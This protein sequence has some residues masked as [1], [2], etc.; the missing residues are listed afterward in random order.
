M[1]H[2]DVY[3]PPDPSSYG[4]ARGENFVPAEPRVM[5]LVL[6]LDQE[7][8]LWIVVLIGYF[9]CQNRY[10]RVSNCH[11]YIHNFGTREKLIH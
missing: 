6:H 7:G 5:L 11:I 1:K 4:A 10:L 9:N 2:A 3:I 8:P